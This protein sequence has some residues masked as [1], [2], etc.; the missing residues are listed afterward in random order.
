M[1]S[2]KLR[3]FSITFTP[4]SLR[5]Q[6]KVAIFNSTALKPWDSGW[7]ATVWL[8]WILHGAYVAFTL[9]IQVDNPNGSSVT[10]REYIMH[11]L[12]PQ[13]HMASMKKTH[14]EDR[15]VIFSRRFKCSST[16]YLMPYTLDI[17]WYRLLP[18]LGMF[19]SVS[20]VSCTSK[21]FF[22]SIRTG[23]PH[24]ALWLHSCHQFTKVSPLQM[25]L[26]HAGILNPPS[27][28]TRKPNCWSQSV[29]LHECDCNPAMSIVFF[30]PSLTRF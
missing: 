7:P 27:R 23:I 10:Q 18:A 26:S 17:A 21:H 16:M 24:T 13:Q 29:L 4:S 25:R 11:P 2:T 14:Q 19:S 9:Y 15:G 6:K 20:V 8:K 12:A 30:H 22:R 5:K 28:S 3:S 1:Q